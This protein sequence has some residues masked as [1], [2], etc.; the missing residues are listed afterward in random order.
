[1]FFFFKWRTS[2]P[3]TMSEM[4]LLFYLWPLVLELFKLWKWET[5]WLVRIQNKMLFSHLK[6]IKSFEIIKQIHFDVQSVDSEKMTRWSK[7]NL[8]MK[9]SEIFERLFLIPVF[10]WDDNY[11]FQ[12][13]ESYEIRNKNTTEVFKIF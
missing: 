5:Y 2:L 4:C 6:N 9:I 12:Y 7:I 10:Y 13:A 3:I 11:N 1:M 8:P